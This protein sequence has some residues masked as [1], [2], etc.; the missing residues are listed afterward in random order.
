MAQEWQAT[1]AARLK[2]SDIH[3]SVFE[4]STFFFGPKI[5]SNV[6]NLVATSYAQPMVCNCIMQCLCFIFFYI[7]KCHSKNKK[8]HQM[9]HISITLPKM[10]LNK[11]NDCLFLQF[12]KTST[13]KLVYMKCN[14]SKTLKPELHDIIFFHFQTD[15]GSRYKQLSFR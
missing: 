6:R 2:K 4:N 1:L 7:S 13:G 10:I 8:A 11:Y 5:M 3:F 14:L 9:P 15:S 12:F